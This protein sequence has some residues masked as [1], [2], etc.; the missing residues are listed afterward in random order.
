MASIDTKL[1]RGL[2]TPPTSASSISSTPSS[3][4]PRKEQSYYH[5][6]KR[7][8]SA[9]HYGQQGGWFSPRR[10]RTLSE[11]KASAT[12]SRLF[13]WRHRRN[14]NGL[15]FSSGSGSGSSGIMGGSGVGGIGFGSFDDHVSLTGRSGRTGTS[16]FWSR[17]SSIKFQYRM[18]VLLYVALGCVIPYYVMKHAEQE[19]WMEEQYLQ[20]QQRQQQEDINQRQ[21]FPAVPV[22]HTP[23]LVDP[24][25]RQAFFQDVVLGQPQ[26]DSSSTVDN[27]NEVLPKKRRP[28]FRIKQQQQQQ[29]KPFFLPPPS[30]KATEDDANIEQQIQQLELLQQSYRSTRTLS[31]LTANVQTAEAYERV[32][33]RCINLTQT[34]INRKTA[35]PPLQGLSDRIVGTRIVGEAA[36][37]RFRELMAAALDAG[38]WVYEADRDYPDFGGA[39]GWNK[40]KKTERDRDPAIDRPPFPE[41]GKY[42]WEP[43]ALTGQDWDMANEGTGN[44]EVLPAAASQNETNNRNVGWYASRIRPSDFCRL[45][46]TRHMMLVGD[47]IHWQLHDAILYN[48]FDNPQ[49]CYGDLACHLGVG[50]PLCPLPN[51]VRMKF[52]RND[53]LSTVRPKMT[54]LN[55]TKTQNPVEMPWLKDL[56]IKD[57]VILGASH[58]HPLSDTEFRKRLTDTLLK[59]RRTRPDT[60]VIYRNQHLGHPNCPSKA[61]G[62]NS[63]YHEHKHD[64]HDHSY[65]PNDQISPPTQQKQQ[66]PLVPFNPSLPTA[67]S[68]QDEQLR[69][70]FALQSSLMDVQSVVT[71]ASAAASQPLRHEHSRPAAKP[72]LEA[73]PVEELLHYPLD[74]VHYD[75]QNRMAKMLV[76]AAG[77]IYWNVATMTNLRPDGHQGDQDCL[78]YKRPGPTDEWAV[79]F[80]H[81]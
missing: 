2:G 42:H 5:P 46:G 63:A 76:E 22:V 74:W 54:R 19:R 72:L 81:D 18:L 27:N 21:Q 12:L 79:S 49:A 45:L 23:E 66:H 60:L 48:M 1:I 16:G 43:S 71:T 68:P 56:R 65:P 55:E 70:V 32:M 78:S 25:K 28:S 9:S 53:L 33:A 69:R 75:R 67:I 7:G 44:G 11:S 6:Y 30:L 51:D 52:V 39:T 29:N 24:Y 4:T 20:Q 37:R 61:N 10:T 58:F 38:Q 41:A 31:G 47:M 59:I 17:R 77:G 40:K 26:P 14:N 34:W 73:V 50:H 3:S 8:S 15:L 35:K 64:N 62:Y 80:R 36:T 13:F 57:T